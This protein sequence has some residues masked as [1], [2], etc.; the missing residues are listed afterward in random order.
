LVAGLCLGHWKGSQKSPPVSIDALKPP[1]MF[2]YFQA[3][4]LPLTLLI[5]LKSLIWG[6]GDFIDIRQTNLLEPVH[7]A[8]EWTGATGDLQGE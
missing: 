5:S 1:L 7:S 6:G 3:A 2:R 8:D 4:D